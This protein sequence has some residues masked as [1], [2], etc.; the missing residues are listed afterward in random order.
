MKALKKMT[1]LSG[2]E[3]IPTHF[4]AFF[5]ELKNPRPTSKGNLRNFL[6]DI[7]LLTISAMICGAGY[8]ELMKTFGE[9]QLSC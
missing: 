9:N 8:W 7:M 1:N 4:E 6:S 3:A 2:P 5:S